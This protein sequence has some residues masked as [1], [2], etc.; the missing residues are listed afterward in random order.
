MQRSTLPPLSY[1]QAPSSGGNGAAIGSVV[2]GAIAFCLSIVGL[3]PG[4]TVT[5]Y[6]A[7]GVIAIIG[8]VRTLMRR[9]GGSRA[10]PIIAIALG[11]I[12]VIFM[13]TGLVI[14]SGSIP[15]YGTAPASQNQIQSGT[16]TGTDTGTGDTS[17][18]ANMPATPSFASDP[19]LSE[20]ETKAALISQQVQLAY[21]PK[22][23]ARLPP[24]RRR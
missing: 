3:M 24:I 6:S 8:G 11:T 15:T 5:Y 7:G 14:H 23:A 22:A 21:G 20:Y 19:G 13:A 12:A 1:A 16:G 4:A 17:A 2:V 9:H 18:A 10:I